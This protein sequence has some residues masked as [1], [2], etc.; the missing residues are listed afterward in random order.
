MFVQ[1]HYHWAYFHYSSRR[2]ESVRIDADRK[3]EDRVW[4]ENW[5]LFGVIY[6]LY[7]IFRCKEID[8]IVTYTTFPNIIFFCSLR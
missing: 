6:Q 7:H 3:Q 4:R 8:L 2:I 1:V 5:N